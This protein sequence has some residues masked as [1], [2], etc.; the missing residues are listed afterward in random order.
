MRSWALKA[1]MEMATNQVNCR[2]AGSAN[3]SRKAL[4]NRTGGTGA[5]DRLACVCSATGG[6]RVSRPMSAMAVS[7]LANSVTPPATCSRRSGVNGSSN[8][9]AVPAVMAKPAIIIIQTSVAAP[10]RRVGRVRLAKRV[11]T[12]V[13]HALTPTPIK[14]KPRLTTAKPEAWPSGMSVVPQAASQ[15]PALKSSMPPRIHGVHQPD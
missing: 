12:E 15:P 4:K 10:A 9:P 1:S 8:W 3:T 11:S 14:R 13:P 7:A 5:S 2:V 6:R